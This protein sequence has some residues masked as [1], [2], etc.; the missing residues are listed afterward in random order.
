MAYWGTI[1]TGTSYYQV[2]VAKVAY[3]VG[4]RKNSPVR[5]GILSEETQTC[6]ENMAY[7]PIHLSSTSDS[8]CEVAFA[9]VYRPF[10]SGC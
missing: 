8:P 9:G 6:F 1:T 7:Y 3:D 5:A 10:D 2:T 4:I